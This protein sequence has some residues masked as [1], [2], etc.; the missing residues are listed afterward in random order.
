MGFGLGKKISS[1]KTE[2]EVGGVFTN[3]WGR[4]YGAWIGSRGGHSSGDVIENPS[5]MIES[6]IRD[7]IHAERDLILT[8]IIAVTPNV[9]LEIEK[10]AHRIAEDYYNGSYF[11]N[12][13]NNWTALV[14]DYATPANPEFTFSGSPGSYAYLDN[15]YLTNVNVNLNTTLFDALE[16]ARSTWTFARSINKKIKAFDLLN[17]L[18]F[19]SHSIL[20]K[21]NDEYKIV[22]RY[23]YRGD[24]K[25]KTI[26]I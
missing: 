17:E 23:T 6:I 20:F 19:E 13:N 14:T 5:G 4:E 1:Y 24:M 2:Q 16:T 15:V 25:I 10:V 12:I 26:N 8:D 21:S 3:V 22:N 7:E 18:C 9:I 11:H